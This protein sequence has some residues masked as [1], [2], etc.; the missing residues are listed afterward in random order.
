MR[1][2]AHWLDGEY[3]S[4]LDDRVAMLKRSLKVHA[5][6]DDTLVLSDIQLIDSPII[7]KLF[8][9]EA[10]RQF[11]RDFPGF[12]QVVA[13]PTA[14][15]DRYAIVS[16]CLERAAREGWVPS[17]IKKTELVVN[18]AHTILEAGS[19]DPDF[20]QTKAGHDLLTSAGDYTSDLVG[21]FNCLNHFANGSENV[22]VR[23]TS[24]SAP[25][26]FYSVLGAMR[27]RTDLGPEDRHQ[28]EA[29]MD[30]I[31][32]NVEPENRSF[33]SA[34]ITRIGH[35]PWT[36]EQQLIR[37]TVT[38][39]WNCAVEAT[40]EPDAGSTARLPHSPL[41][42]AY[43]N[44]PYNG[45]LS[46][47]GSRKGLAQ[48]LPGLPGTVLPVKWDPLLMSWERLRVLATET[49]EE[50]SSWRSAQLTPSDRDAF[51]RLIAAISAKESGNP[52]GATA[53]SSMLIN[54]VA[55]ATSGALGVLL[56]GGAAE[57]VG[58]AAAVAL[59][60]AAISRAFQRSRHAQ[61][62]N[63][64]RKESA[65]TLGRPDLADR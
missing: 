51:E 29:T 52:A 35:P 42:G 9:N 11:L 31:D 20:L 2:Y 58:S 46:V 5:L 4:A 16:R 65:I 53:A 50:R 25:E 61:I 33:R 6:L 1:V 8:A 23:A 62:V 28:V 34:V 7:Y 37:N 3:C 10:F 55:S 26:T 18:F 47:E 63:T 17:G 24:R 21:I 48:L 49:Y 56:G 15:A 59:V 36:A 60:Q 39:A 30:W 54:A 44:D 22:I 38:Q 14:G 45:L 41:I 19:V 27:D 64:L 32:A 12:L 13:Q 57:V 40:I 43:M